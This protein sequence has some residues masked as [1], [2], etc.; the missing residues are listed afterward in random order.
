MFAKKPRM[1]ILMVSIQTG[2]DLFGA[3]MA[4]QIGNL[5]WPNTLSIPLIRPAMRGSMPAQAALLGL[6]AY[7]WGGFSGLCSL[8][9]CSWEVVKFTSNTIQNAATWIQEQ[10]NVLINTTA[11]VALGAF[12][13]RDYLKPSALRAAKQCIDQVLEQPQALWQQMPTFSLAHPIE[14]WNNIKLHLQCSPLLNKPEIPS[15]LTVIL[16]N[17]TLNNQLR[18]P[19][20]LF[21]TG[22]SPFSDVL[23]AYHKKIQSAIS[24]PMVANK[25]VFQLCQGT[26]IDPAFIARCHSALGSAEAI[27]NWTGKIPLIGYFSGTARFFL[28][29]TIVA[30]SAVAGAMLIAASTVPQRSGYAKIG[31]ALLREYAALHGGSNI[32]RGLVEHYSWTLSLL[33]TLVWDLS[34]KRF[35]Y[36]GETPS[37]Y[38]MP[39]AAP[40][41]VQ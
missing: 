29:M 35:T 41:F 7:Q 20:A 30:V 6:Q 34:G 1:R 32:L 28:G 39:F 26:H 18:G 33:T 25:R 4:R 17:Q 14:S 12:L 38:H 19:L 11:A 9:I 15:A 23:E 2:A 13:C 36:L 16:Q 24:P 5:S 40:H 8:G 37:P 31:T 3:Y 22:L 21:Q 10:D 27:L